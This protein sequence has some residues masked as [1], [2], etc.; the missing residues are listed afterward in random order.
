MGRPPKCEQ[1]RARRQASAVK[2]RADTFDLARPVHDP[3]TSDRIYTDDEREFLAACEEYSQRYRRRFM[4]ASEYL[5]VAI[6][7][8]YRKTTPCPAPS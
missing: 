5:H 8:G 4:S 6:A 1:A 7:I 2:A 3:V